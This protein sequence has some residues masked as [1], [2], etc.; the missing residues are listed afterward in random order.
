VCV[1][2]AAV[3]LSLSL[4]QFVSQIRVLLATTDN[5]R[6]LAQQREEEEQRATQQ[7]EERGIITMGGLAAGH[8]REV[9]EGHHI[10][11]HTG[12]IYTLL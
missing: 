9:P 1:V 10:R 7:A 3:L 11:I 4:H 5:T 12:V 6:A 2:V 8:H